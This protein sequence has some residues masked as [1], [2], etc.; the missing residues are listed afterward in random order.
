MTCQ[1]LFAYRWIQAGH[2]TC[3]R[4]EAVL[5]EDTGIHGQCVRCNV[6]RSGEW[7]RYFKF[8]L[9]EY[10]QKE[11][12]RLMDLSLSDVELTNTQLRDLYIR[13]KRGVE[14]LENL[15]F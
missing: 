10:G 8:M 9:A 13:F 7:V 4:S 11:V 12:N 5:F 6:F 3:G 1:Q 14:E 2:F 15:T